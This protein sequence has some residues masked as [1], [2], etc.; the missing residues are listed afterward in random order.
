MTRNKKEKRGKEKKETGTGGAQGPR[1]MA[2][3]KAMTTSKEKTA[4]GWL[5]TLYLSSFAVDKDYLDIA[6]TLPGHSRIG[7]AR[8]GS[9]KAGIFRLK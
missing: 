1:T 7:T 2:E 8:A 9:D 4:E 6:V 5:A 3:P